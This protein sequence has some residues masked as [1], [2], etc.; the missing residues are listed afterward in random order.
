M[1][2]LIILIISAIMLLSGCAST[3]ETAGSEDD[4]TTPS[5]DVETREWDIEEVGNSFVISEDVMSSKENKSIKITGVA[6]E[7]VE[8]KKCYNNAEELYGVFPAYGMIELCFE[9][10]IPLRVS[11]YVKDGMSAEAMEIVFDSPTVRNDLRIPSSR[12]ITAWSDLTYKNLP[13]V[14]LRIV[15]QYKE[16]TVEYYMTMKAA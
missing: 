15:C 9:Q 13:K 6:A 7:D 4:A 2:H 5:S 16:K 1:K 3:L 10:E 11:C 14:K 8:T 12:Y